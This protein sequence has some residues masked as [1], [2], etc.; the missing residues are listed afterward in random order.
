MAGMER[1]ARL[2]GQ[3][4]HPAVRDVGFV[5]PPERGQAPSHIQLSII[6]RKRS[7]AAAR[8]A[9][10][11]WST[12]A[13]FAVILVRTVVRRFALW[14]WALCVVSDDLIRRCPASAKRGAALAHTMSAFRWHRSAFMRRPPAPFPFG[15]RHQRRYRQAQRPSE[16][17]RHVDARA[18]LAPFNVPDV[19][20][21]DIS[22]FR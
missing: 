1:A 14:T 18:A 21:V 13:G 22:K 17:L 11:W 19:H 9:E 8:R 16:P 7:L 5:K 6:G 4:Q 10:C 12:T 2:R 15:F 20:R 3:R